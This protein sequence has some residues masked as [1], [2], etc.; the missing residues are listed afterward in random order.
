VVPAEPSGS[1]NGLLCGRVEA[2]HD[3]WVGIGFS[4]DGLM[5]GSQA[6]IGI[7]LEGTVLKYDLTSAATPMSEE[8]Q[9]L[10]D[11]SITLG[12]EGM[13]IMEFAKLL[14]EEGE[15]P[16][17]EDAENTFLHARGSVTL[18]YHSSRTSFVVVLSPVR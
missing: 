18:G 11:T 12:V 10:T 7:P 15:V 9:T 8:R 6:V 17:L 3:G 5:A 13:V 16:I 14:V 2:V 1:G 4:A